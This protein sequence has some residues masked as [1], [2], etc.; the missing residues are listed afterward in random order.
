MPEAKRLLEFC[1]QENPK[2]VPALTDLGF[3][4]LQMGDAA[5]AEATYRKAL[6]LNPDYEP[7]MMNWAGW[8]LHAQRYADAQ[9][10]LTKII[11]KYPNN[12][13]AKQVLAQVRTM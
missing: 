1:V 3:T 10:Y 7:L 8:L 6:A 2:F 9:I 11:K 5:R 4:Y 12:A 13:Q